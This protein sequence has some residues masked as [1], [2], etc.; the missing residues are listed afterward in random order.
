MRPR[1]PHGEHAPNQITN[2]SIYD[3]C[4]WLQLS[5]FRS[6]WRVF[7]QLWSR[8]RGFTLCGLRSIRVQGT[9]CHEQTVELS[10]RGGGG[11]GSEQRCPEGILVPRGRSLF[12]HLSL[13]SFSRSLPRPSACSLSR[14][15]ASSLSHLPLCLLAHLPC[16]HHWRTLASTLADHGKRVRSNQLQ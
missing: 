4:C 2:F 3:H 7:V 6:K 1:T 9:C 10:A 12:F 11:G 5:L 13:I 14:P 16:A 15:S 8:F